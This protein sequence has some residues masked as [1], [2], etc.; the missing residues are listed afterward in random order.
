MPYLEMIGL[1]RGFWI[2]PT[3]IASIGQAKGNQAPG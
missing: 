3:A 2:A 1:D